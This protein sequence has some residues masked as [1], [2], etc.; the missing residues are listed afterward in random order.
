MASNLSV[1]QES[2]LPSWPH[3]SRKWLAELYIHRMF[4][5]D[6]R[7]MT[8]I[9]SHGSGKTAFLLHDLLPSLRQHGTQFAYVDCRALAT[10]TSDNA[11]ATPDDAGSGVQKEANS[12]R[13]WDTVWRSGLF[14]SQRVNHPEAMLHSTESSHTR[15]VRLGQ[16]AQ[17]LIERFADADLPLVLVYDDVHEL[18]P[19][20]GVILAQALRALTR[21]RSAFT[22]CLLTSAV[23][24]LWAD[25]SAAN[26]ATLPLREPHVLPPL[27]HDF[28]EQVADWLKTRALGCA[29]NAIELDVTWR[30][31]G[32]SPR[33]F[34]DVLG[35]VLRG[36]HDDLAAA[37]ES[38]RS[39]A[40]SKGLAKLE[41]FRLSSLQA[42]L[43]REVWLARTE[44]YGAE[45]RETFARLAN[46]AD[47]SKTDVQGGLK[48]L[49]R[50]GLVCREENSR[51]ELCSL[52]VEELM[53]LD[54]I[55]HRAEMR[56][57]SLGADEATEDPRS[58]QT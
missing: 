16:V 31:V 57:H 38:V 13:A 17:T 29:S 54:K 15:L 25:R 23:R 36:D 28:L 43:L 8:L 41:E 5:G 32:R 7:A 2:L 37:A 27:G 52:D 18:T 30:A 49:E 50:R 1:P 45:H 20:K 6:E 14:V 58:I 42:V 11:S 19:A 4:D 9:G 46:M 55:Q 48:R 53:N 12:P 39:N 26:D 51:Y 44:F 10:Q 40:L 47:V 34:R 21:G 3:H 56:E 22:G 24:R 33:L 35:S